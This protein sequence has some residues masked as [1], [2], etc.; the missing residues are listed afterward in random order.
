MH[1]PLTFG[2]AELS[3]A[4]VFHEFRVGVLSTPVCH[5]PHPL[6]FRLLRRELRLQHAEIN[7][8]IRLDTV[9]CGRFGHRYRTSAPCPGRTRIRN[10]RTVSRPFRSTPPHLVPRGTEFGG[11][12]EG[13]EHLLPGGG[14]GLLGLVLDGGCE[15]K[16][17]I[18][19]SASACCSWPRLPAK[20]VD[21]MSG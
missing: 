4:H 6:Q 2:D 17:C 11:E 5:D 3:L 13:S 18:F 19:A 7:H 8:N 9:L 14:N 10:R 12:P 16:Y 20:V 21:T 15:G 1:H